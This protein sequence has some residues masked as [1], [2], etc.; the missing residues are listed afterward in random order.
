MSAA[1]IV[2]DVQRD[3]C[4]GGALAVPRGDEVIPTLNTYLRRAQQHGILVYVS[5]DWHPQRSTHFQAYGGPWPVHCV[6]ETAGAAFH[7]TLEL[8]SN[9]VVV[10]K[11]MGAT[12]DGYSAFEAQTDGGLFLEDALRTEDIDCLCIGGLATDYCVR[13]TVLEACS[14]GFRTILLLDGSRGVNVAPGDS[15]RAI[16]EMVRAG[17][18]VTTLEHIG[19]LQPELAPER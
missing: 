10:S 19:K 6:Q 5:R 18:Y 17:A 13:A 4:P 2:V 7:P 14:K 9:A 11:G 3:F 8:P 15:E 16:V 12:D 1:L